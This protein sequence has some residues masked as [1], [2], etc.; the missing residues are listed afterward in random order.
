LALPQ[1]HFNLQ[2]LNQPDGLVDGELFGLNKRGN[3]NLNLRGVGDAAGAGVGLAGTSAAVLV[4]R[5]GLGV[6]VGDSAAESVPLSAGW[7]ASVSFCVRRF[8]GEGDSA[9]KGDVA[10]SAGG[11]AFALFGVEG[12]RGE[13]DSAGVPVSSCD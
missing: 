10:L 8:G 6:V 7:V 12:F 4:R 1:S 9:A 11:V 2:A 13:G 3:L 5:F